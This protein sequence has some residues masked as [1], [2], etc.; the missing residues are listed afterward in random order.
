MPARAIP[1]YSSRAFTLI[2]LLVV[3]AIIAILIGLL[4]P[5][6]QKVREAAVRIQC[7]NN[8]RQLTLAVMQFEITHQK[9]PLSFTTPN[10]SNWPYS[11]T[12]WFGL[13]DPAN[14]VDTSKGL[15]TPYYENNKKVALCPGL[16]TDQVKG[17]YNSSTGGYGYNRCLGSTYWNTGNW[18]TALKL[19]R[20][21]GE[22]A[23]S[24][25]FVFS[26][27]A[28]IAS[29]T[30]PPEAQESYSLAAPGATFPGSTPQPTTHFR[31]AS[32]TSLVSFLDGHVETRT[33]V[34]VANPSWW[35]ASANK[36]KQDLR[37]GYLADS[38]IPYDGK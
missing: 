29:W 31:H 13:V 11:T 10:P 9:L 25:T 2:E 27:S 12:Y 18:T 16:M 24:S 19:E 5:S 20:R 7:A 26:D 34:A 22:F 30:N 8:I 4:L 36:V 17:V 28:L 37:I 6:V 15:L 21:I 35:P 3:I 33:E 14:N 32:G 38:N 1:G 23:T